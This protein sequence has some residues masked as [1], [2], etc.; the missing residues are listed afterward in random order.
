[1]INSTKNYLD[2][3]YAPP[4]YVQFNNIN[5]Q[6][7]ITHNKKLAILLILCSF[8]VCKVFFCNYRTLGYL[9]NSIKMY[10]KNWYW[11]FSIEFKQL[12]RMVG[13]LF[14]K[15]WLLFSLIWRDHNII[16]IYF[17]FRFLSRIAYLNWIKL[18]H[19]NY[20]HIVNSS[21]FFIN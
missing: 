6:W 8:S 13:V 15:S 2:R 21:V 20:Y 4:K 7:D 18:L 11:L 3:R 5:G 17:S 1:M 10:I 9:H 12:L 14:K 19:G 16:S